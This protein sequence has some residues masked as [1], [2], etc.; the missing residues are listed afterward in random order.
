MRQKSVYA[1]IAST[2]HLVNYAKCVVLL[3]LLIVEAVQR[4]LI[5]ARAHASINT[6]RDV[7]VNVHLVLVSTT[8]I[9]TSGQAGMRC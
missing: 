1:L 9:N 8:R 2:L 5:F 3:S 4:L 7:C 6:L